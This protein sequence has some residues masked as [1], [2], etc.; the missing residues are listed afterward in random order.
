MFF[1]KTENWFNFKK[2]RSIKLQK[3]SFIKKL[4]YYF[5]ENNTKTFK[6]FNSKTATFYFESN[7]KRQ[8]YE[9][10]T[11]CSSSKSRS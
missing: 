3:H 4:Y 8:I 5:R 2:I 6:W 7:K 11:F 1:S 9:F 10:F